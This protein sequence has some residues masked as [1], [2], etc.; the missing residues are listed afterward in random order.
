MKTKILVGESRS[1]K[2]TGVQKVFSV[3]LALMEMSGH[4][5]TNLSGKNAGSVYS[6]NKGGKYVRTRAIPTNPSSARQSVVR[7]AFS[8][9]SAGWK[10][11][12]ASQRSAWNSVTATFPRIN[13]LGIPIVISGINLYK[14]LNQNLFNAGQ[15][16]ISNPPVAVGATNVT[17]LSGAASVGGSTFLLTFAPTPTALLNTTLVFATAQLSPGISS[18][19]NRLRLITTLP[20]AT[21]TGATVY[22]S[23]IAKFGALVLGQKIGIGLVAVQNV[24]GEKST[25]IQAS[26]IVAA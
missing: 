18:F 26:L 24:C 11:L 23:Y 8:S 22:A 10:L 1:P 25:M 12:T 4:G 20:A 17:S 9:F 19:K 7:G 21:A 6:H 5:I 13:R 16:A 15:A 14:S 3:I 2:K